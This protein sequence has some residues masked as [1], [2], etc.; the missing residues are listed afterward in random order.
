MRC[1]HASDRA[2][3]SVADR[4]VKMEDNRVLIER[5][6]L[7]FLTD[8]RRDDL[9]ELLADVTGLGYVVDLDFG[10]EPEPGKYGVT[11]L[12]VVAIY[13][14]AKVLDGMTAD[15]IDIAVKKLANTAVDW[16]KARFRKHPDN[17]RPQYISL[18]GPDGELL[19]SVQVDPK[20]DVQDH[21]ERDRARQE[22]KRKRKRKD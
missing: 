18:Y 1:T 13:V 11:W 6:G 3:N 22:R 5:G 4:L 12:E 15:A 2:N 7:E 17:T 16:A 19:K 21:T 9:Q 14:G 20:G 10:P 8:Q